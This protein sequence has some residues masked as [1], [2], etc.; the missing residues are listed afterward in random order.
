M[1]KVGE[2]KYHIDFTSQQFPASSEV[3]SYKIHDRKNL[4]DGPATIE[5]CGLLRNRVLDYIAT[6]TDSALL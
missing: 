4:G 5:R 3:H 2:T 1:I 6:K